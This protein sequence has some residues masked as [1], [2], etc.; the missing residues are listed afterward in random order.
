MRSKSK[1][2]KKQIPFGNDKQMGV[3]LAAIER[4]AK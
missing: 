4:D 1:Q 3:V 2:K